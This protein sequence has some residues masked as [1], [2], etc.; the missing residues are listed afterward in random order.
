MRREFRASPWRLS[1]NLTPLIDV[2]FQLLIFFLC[3]NQSEKAEAEARIHLPLAPE[4]SESRSRRD[5]QRLVLQRGRDSGWRAS[6]ETIP[7]GQLPAWLAKQAQAAAPAPIEV[8]IRA[9][10]SIPFR[11]IE[12]ALTACAEA[13]IWRVTFKVQA[14]PGRSEQ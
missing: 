14:E 10:R 11:E 13:G 7:I 9:D 4:S 6:G 5:T 12:P 8:W 3:V 2:I 1:F